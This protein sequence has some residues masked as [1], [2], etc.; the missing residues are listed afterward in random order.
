VALVAVFGDY[1]FS[2]RRL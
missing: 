2:S 1:S